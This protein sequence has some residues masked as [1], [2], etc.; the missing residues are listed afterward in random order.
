MCEPITEDNRGFKYTS[1]YVKSLETQNKKL[2]KLV[3]ELKALGGGKASE[4]V[5]NFETESS[6]I[7]AAQLETSYPGTENSSNMKD[8]N[9]DSGVPNGDGLANGTVETTDIIHVHAINENTES[10]EPSIYGPSFIYVPSAAHS[11]GSPQIEDFEKFHTRPFVD[12]L[13]NFF[14]WRYPDV[15][16]FIHRESF[17]T[18]FYKSKNDI[19][20]SITYCSEE[21][22]Y[23][24][25][26]LGSVGLKDMVLPG[27]KKPA[28]QFYQLARNLIFEKLRINQYSSI[29][30]IQ[31]LLAL[32]IYDLGRGNNTSAW[33]LSGIAVRI[34]EDK[35][36]S[37]D[38]SE[39]KS[40]S[41]DSILSD[42][43]IAVRSRIYWGCYSAEHFIANVLGR[44]SILNSKQATIRDTVD[45]PHLLGIEQF[46]YH[47]PLI[48]SYEVK[49]DVSGHLKVL[50][51]MYRICENYKPLI[52]FKRD[53]NSTDTHK[54][55]EQLKQLT[56]ELESWKKSLPLKLQWNSQILKIE[57]H[58]QVLM[59]VRN[60]YYLALLSFH[61]P[62]VNLS[63]L[64]QNYR[65]FVYETCMNV[66]LDLKIA[67]DSYLH[68]QEIEK[69]SLVTVY[70]TILVIMILMS[71]NEEINTSRLEILNFFFNLLRQMAVSWEI[72]GK[73]YH[74]IMS[75]YTS[76]IKSNTPASDHPI[77]LNYE[78][79][80]SINFSTDMVSNSNKFLLDFDNEFFKNEDIP[81]IFTSILQE[82]PDFNE[83]FVG[84]DLDTEF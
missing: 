73:Y 53:T 72:A 61:R 42:Y 76:F 83:G 50:A 81:S 1:V 20:V 64:T 18:D 21:L 43:D 25:C 29:V 69:C 56:H 57:G 13:V 36:L 19:K 31:S 65:K 37:L 4:L 34:G 78:V 26:C 6:G 75:T 74:S 82:M 71:Q 22:I 62:F 67:I 47:D 59:N 38:P 79:P 7:E 5:L 10:G 51:D 30:M 14:V 17:L 55:M 63:M 41:G 16:M 46:C 77:D 15:T 35:G 68:V 3:E 44:M 45:L 2:V 48:K 80:E 40:D 24:L 9:I 32:S 8:N 28:E 66:I 52:F 58:N 60:Q 84:F 23:A 39:W 33:L 54:L 12:L 70:N 11:T 27:I 49:L